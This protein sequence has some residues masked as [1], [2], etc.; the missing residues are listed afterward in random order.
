MEYPGLEDFGVAPFGFVDL[1]YVGD[2]EDVSAFRR[3]A[4]QFLPR[5]GERIYPDAGSPS[6]TVRSVRYRLD[7]MADLDGSLIPVLI[8]LVVVS[9]D[10]ERSPDEHHE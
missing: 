6:V 3:M 4:C 5:V 7:R 2:E 1:V 10:D 8:P 9:D